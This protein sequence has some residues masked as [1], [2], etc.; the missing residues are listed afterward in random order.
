MKVLY[1]N[2]S[3]YV[4]QACALGSIKTETQLDEIKDSFIRGKASAEGPSLAL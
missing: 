2:I 4:L 1:G 3:R